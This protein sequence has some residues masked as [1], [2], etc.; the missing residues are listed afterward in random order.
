M[1]VASPR[2]MCVLSPPEPSGRG[3]L[4]TVGVAGRA[5]EL[6][7]VPSSPSTPSGSTEASIETHTPGNRS[8]YYT[9][10]TAHINQGK[11][12]S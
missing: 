2:G 11:A 8:A 9:A 1:D 5:T 7:L 12:K 6:V 3:Y 10:Y 4:I